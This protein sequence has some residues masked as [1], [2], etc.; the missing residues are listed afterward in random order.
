[1]SRPAH[2]L[3]ARMLLAASLY[4]GFTAS[5][6]TNSS[7]PAADRIRHAEQ[8]PGG[9][10]HD[11]CL[12]INN[13]I[14]DLP[15]AG[16]T[17]DARSF[18]GKQTCGM[19]VRLKVP[20][21]LL[22]GGATYSWSFKGPIFSIESVGCS[23]EGLGRMNSTILTPP[24]GATAIYAA[25]G[26]DSSAIRHINIIGP[27]SD[28]PAFA[29]QLDAGAF[30]TN[31]PTFMIED[32]Y[33]WGGN[34]G[35][36]AIR[37]INS[38]LKDV[39]VSHVMS[40]GFSFVGDGTTVTCINCYANGNGRS[41]FHVSGIA[42]ATFV[43]GETDTNKGDGLLADTASDK[44]PTSG[45]T[46]TGLDVE[47]NQGMGIHLVN[48]SGTSISGSVII[49][50]ASDGIGMCG[51]TGFSMSGGRISANHGFGIDLTPAGCSQVD[52]RS[53]SDVV[54]LTPWNDVANTSG[55]LNDPR[56]VA[57][58]YVPSQTSPTHM[59]TVMLGGASWGV[60]TGAPGSNCKTGSLY[61]D[62]SGGTGTTLYVCEG[63]VW[64]AK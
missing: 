59:A 30:P 4:I 50:N 21:R 40:D 37:P 5:A 13:A 17:V 25:K 16:G 12:Q 34:S 3:A 14:S 43:G 42:N 47:A 33:I 35:I 51:G 29:I 2:L 48:S 39:R 15:A 55:F 52:W 28:V 11:P 24:A 57:L 19:G 49:N 9:T 46:L 60:G 23:I 44:Q 62:L 64:K 36:Q 38:T 54:I 22:L 7:S 20:V 53:A 31:N 27:L 41:G 18:E 32:V 63:S 61:T 26:L 58:T 10:T 45:L 8:F 56:H 1:M 6:A